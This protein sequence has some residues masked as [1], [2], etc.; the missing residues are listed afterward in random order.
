[1]PSATPEFRRH[2]VDTE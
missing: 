2:S 1:M